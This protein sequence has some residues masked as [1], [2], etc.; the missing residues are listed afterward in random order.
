[1][2]KSKSLLDKEED[3]EEYRKLGIIAL[4][5]PAFRESFSISLLLALVLSF[6]LSKNVCMKL[7]ELFDFEKR[8]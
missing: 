8:E 7:F 3:D 5:L 1:M 4:A 2:S 6:S